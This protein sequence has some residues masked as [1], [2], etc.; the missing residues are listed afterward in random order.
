[1]PNTIVENEELF[2]PPRS[3]QLRCPVCGTTYPPDVEGCPQH[4]DTLVPAD[5]LVGI[6]LKQTWRLD[7]PLG[8]GGTALVYTAR[9]ITLP[10]FFAVKVL[11]TDRARDKAHRERFLREAE[12]QAVLQHDNVARVIDYGVDEKTDILFVAM[13]QVRGETLKDVV[14]R[15]GPMP[16]QRAVDIACQIL[17]AIGA[18]HRVGTLHRDLKPQNVMLTTTAGL[19]D[20]VRV[21][22]FGGKPIERSNQLPADPRARTALTL[23]GTLFGTPAYM[24]P[25]QARGEA[26]DERS[27]I[28][29]AAVVLLHMLIGR[30]PF[31]GKDL[32]ETL[33]RV[34]TMMPPRP[35]L[36]L[37]EAVEHI[38]PGL[39]IV[40]LKALSKDPQ[41]RFKTAEEFKL[42]LLRFSRPP[43]PR[44]RD[45]VHTTTAE[46][47]SESQTIVDDG[48]EPLAIRRIVDELLLNAA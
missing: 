19:K 31:R 13:E 41:I 16:V 33:S 35:S 36:V 23:V 38:P 22:D 7:E 18:A 29:A 10:G 45:A 2:G 26:L 3:T 15:V 43:D 1:V 12:A 5:P 32:T 34:L 25:E 46:L 21:L 37:R 20:R 6:V 11:A 44:G 14:D 17:D 42:A 40:L 24:S 27:D 9:H 28:Y 30:S 4:P 48:S 39:E 8:H 47:A